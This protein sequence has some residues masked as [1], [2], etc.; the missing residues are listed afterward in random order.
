MT[1]AIETPP[2]EP[3]VRAPHA[4]HPIE[5]DSEDQPDT[6][7][8]A[9]DV[10]DGEVEVRLPP[11]ESAPG[12]ARVTT[13]AAL[14]RWRL[15]AF[16]DSVLLAVSE[17]VTNAVRHGAPPARLR[18][19]RSPD[20]LVVDVHDAS[21][22]LPGMDQDGVAAA[23]AESGRGLAIVAAIADEVQVEPVPDDGKTIHACFHTEPTPAEQ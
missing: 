17:L 8:R 6:A 1:A 12:T 11:D 23:D 15:P 16:A 14:N 19:A 2:G 20:R 5:M 13:R 9:G 4:G 7:G 3:G 21:P 18:L 22:S 10:P